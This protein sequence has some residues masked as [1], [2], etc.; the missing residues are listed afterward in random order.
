MNIEQKIF[1]HHQMQM[2]FNHSRAA[3]RQIGLART[4]T[5]R[6]SKLTYG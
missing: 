4:L 3:V 2:A 1:S 5:T 6:D